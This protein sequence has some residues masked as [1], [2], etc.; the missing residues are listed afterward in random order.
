MDVRFP[1]QVLDFA[2]RVAAAVVA[3]VGDDEQRLARIVALLHLVQGH[4]DGVKQSGPALGLR[5]GQA[6]LDV[7]DVGCE[8]LDQLGA[9]VELHQ[10]EFVF[11][12][13]GLEKLGNGLAGLAQLVPHAA[14]GV[15]NQ[16]DRKRRILAGKMDDL[17]LA[18]VLEHLKVLFLQAGYK[19]VQGIGYGDVDQD[20]RR[21]YTD[22]ASWPFGG[23]WGGLG[24]RIDR[25]LR[26]IRAPSKRCNQ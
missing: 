23:R 19:A 5:E 2:L 7:L 12:I 25:D 8:I 26:T 1:H 3:S 22:V 14:A 13:G 15:K 4:V 10:E 9:V 11:R 24:S 18:L 6:I 16:T 17:L 20:D 21:V